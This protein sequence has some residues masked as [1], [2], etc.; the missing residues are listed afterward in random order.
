MNTEREAEFYEFKWKA[1]FLTV[2]FMNDWHILSRL[3]VGVS[4]F[5]V[6]LRHV[7][8]EVVAKPS[9]GKLTFQ[10][11]VTH[12]PTALSKDF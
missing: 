3:R 9:I 12:N 8:L 1:E 5:S 2:Y 4:V 6:F 10:T 11:E 7:Q